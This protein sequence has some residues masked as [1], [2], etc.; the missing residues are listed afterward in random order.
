MSDE[1]SDFKVR[2]SDF[3]NASTYLPTYVVSWCGVD[4]ELDGPLRACAIRG[5]PVWVRAITLYSSQRIPP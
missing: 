3:R 1:T 4:C 5:Q 2:L